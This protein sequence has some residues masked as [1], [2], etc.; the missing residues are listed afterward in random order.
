[1]PVG[2]QIIEL[3]RY[4]IFMPMDGFEGDLDSSVLYAGESCSLVSD[5]RPAA[6]IVATLAADADA[7]RAATG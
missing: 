3:P 6:D 1:M 5:V 7:I 4:S 2:G